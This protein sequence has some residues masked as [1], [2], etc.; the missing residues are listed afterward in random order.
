MK[1]ILIPAILLVLCVILLCFLGRRTDDKLVP[2]SSPEPQ[3]TAAADSPDRY[4]QLIAHA[5]GAVY[6]YRL[7]N[8]LEALDQAYQN[9]F[10]YVELDLEL[11]SD[12]QIVLIHDWE[13]CAQRL[14]G[15]AGRRSL[16]SFTSSPV[17][18][19]LHLLTLDQLLEWLT[20]HP[21]CSIITDTKAEDNVSLM[22]QLMD[23]TG[24]Q[25]SAFIPQA[26]SY[27]EFEQ[28]RSIGFDR[29]ILSLYKMSTD[30]VTLTRF[31]QES[32]PWAITIPAESMDQTLLTSLSQ[33]GTKVYA[34]AVDSVDFFDQ[35]R[36]MGLTGLYT[37][38]FSPARW[39]Y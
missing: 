32:Q 12:A 24:E 39:L 19:D 36:S 14:L 38:Y 20:V 10:R 18:A 16:E 23:Q 2:S 31:A 22:E 6:G 27:E 11:T 5:G 26:F 29:V 30:A 4:P 34:H 1:R 35:W 13:G 33:S 21:D 8:S 37:N 7:T 15:A 25:A 3:I 9:G 17:M 28:I